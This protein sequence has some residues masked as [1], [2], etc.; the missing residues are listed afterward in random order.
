MLVARIFRKALLSG[1]ARSEYCTSTAAAG[2]FTSTKTTHNPLEEF[3]ELERN[4]EDEK[5]IVY[6]DGCRL[7]VAR[8]CV[9]IDSGGSRCIGSIDT[10]RIRFAHPDLP[11]ILCTALGIKNLSDVVVETL[12]KIGSVSLVELKMN[13]S[14]KSF[15]ASVYALANG[16]TSSMP[17]FSVHTLEQVQISLV[18]IVETLQFVRYL[19]TRFMLLPKYLEITRAS[20][21]SVIPEWENEPRHQTLYFVNQS[22]P[23][24]IIVEPPLYVSVLNVLAVVVSQVLGSPISLPIG[25]L[26]SGP[27]GSEKGIF[28]A[29]KP[30][31]YRSETGN[32][33]GLAG[34]ELLP[35][36]ALRGEIV[37][38]KTGNDGDKLKYG[39]VS[40]D[41]RP[42][43]GQALYMFMVETA[44]G[45]AEFLVSS[46]VFSFQSISTANESSLST[47]PDE[48]V[49]N[50]Y[51]QEDKARGAQARGLRLHKIFAALP[52]EEKGALRAT[53]FAP[54]MLIDPIATM[55]TLVVEIF[56]RH[57]GDMK[58]QFGETIIQMKLILVCLILGLRVSPIANEF[59]FVNPKHMTN[60]RMWRFPKKKNTYGL[61]EIVD[62]L[63]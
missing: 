41:V 23:Y 39:R 62:A 37:A 6:D 14:S 58:F 42:S 50:Q 38:W 40:G 18:S 12:D 55:S 35:Q 53:Y 54:L 63:K 51:S 7:V 32:K 17:S 60:F 11:E 1:V 2:S 20:K 49:P 15:H 25:S 36:D 19:H 29:L 3:F 57:L 43:A 59:L 61:K 31:S 30:G 9:Y 16:I 24:A 33:D 28:G 8:S 34:K 10:S 26:L 56:D 44:P 46:Q 4:L 47:F 45:D 5:P 13:L 48:V 27:E 21:G 22:Q 52:E